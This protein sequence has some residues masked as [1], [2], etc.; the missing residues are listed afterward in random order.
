[1]IQ[2]D[3]FKE[4]SFEEFEQYRA[5]SKEN[6]YLVVDVRQENE[7]KS[8]HVPGA[9]L[10]P[11]NILGDHLPELALD[12]DLF[13][14]CH[15]GVRSEVAGIMAAEEGRDAQKIYNITGGFCS[16]QG[17]SLDGFPRLQVF[18]YQEDDT[19]LLYQAMELEKAA[20]HFYE[21]ILAFV[22]DEKFKG[23]IEQLA[24]AEIA[25]ARTI[26]SYWKQIVENPQP[27]E[28]IYEVLK[29]DILESGQPLSEVTT[30]LYANNEITWTD[31]IEMA[32]SIE[33][34]A[35]DLYRTMAD[36]RG[37]GEAQNAFLSI[38][39]MEKAHMK[40]AAKLLDVQ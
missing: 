27:F 4:I 16:Y 2:Q 29:G 15:S 24:K 40:L 35:Y 32:L 12:K 23:T 10:I 28:D 1:M 21:T 11:L 3:D 17:H 36:R 13:F 7:Y 30:A 25:H 22:P 33:I 8:G 9:K 19:R 31:I 18:D 5:D 38:A 37:K 39:Q 20:E 34:Q 14:Y 6:N 26:Y